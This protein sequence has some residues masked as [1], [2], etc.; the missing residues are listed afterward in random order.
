MVEGKPVF[1]IFG[2]KMPKS[3]LKPEWHLQ[4]SFFTSNCWML[5]EAAASPF[6]SPSL[7]N[8]G[9]AVGDQP[10]ALPV[11]A[12]GTALPSPSTCPHQAQ[13]QGWQQTSPCCGS[14]CNVL[15]R[16]CAEMSAGLTAEIKKWGACSDACSATGVV[17]GGMA[18]LMHIE[19]PWWDAC[20]AAFY[21]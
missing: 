1:T 7:P 21:I 15:G 5:S 16:C 12:H 20:W 9:W 19:A 10:P 3:S 8:L 13:K 14:C 18:A 2:S 4:V 11:S 17:P 6:L